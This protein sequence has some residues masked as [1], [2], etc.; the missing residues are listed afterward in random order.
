MNSVFSFRLVILAGLVL[1]GCQSETV[2]KPAGEGV[3][4]TSPQRMS[5]IEPGYRGIAV[6]VSQVAEASIE[7]WKTQDWQQIVLMVD[8]EMESER[9]VQACQLI[10]NAKLP[11]EYFW[12][13]ARCPKLADAHP[14][15]M[16]SLQG[17]DEWRRL[18]PDFPAE[19]SNEVVKT[20]PWVPICYQ[21]S[22]AA[23]LDRITQRLET[24]P[25]PQRVWLHDVQAAPSACGCGHPLCRWTGDYG[26][27]HTAEPLGD[28]A[29]ADFIRK[30]NERFPKIEFVPIWTTEC[31]EEDEH[32]ACGGV[33]CFEGI[34]WNAWTRQL[35]AIEQ[36]SPILGVSS[37][38]K[39]YERDLPRYGQTAA[40]IKSAVSFFE[41][42]PTK[43]NSASVKPDRLVV[44][45]QGWDV[46]DKEI[47]AQVA[48]G[49]TSQ[50][51]GIL[52]VQ[53]Q[54]DQSWEPR[55]FQISN[56]IKH[57]K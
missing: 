19:K 22:F 33:G 25:A 21:E 40:W 54:V 8:D 1:T 52:L 37:F 34:C 47:A 17:H 11:V 39:A 20:Y 6:D 44:V 30:L 42:V 9:I 46:S 51:R 48:H 23:Q 53:P 5:T 18:H 12:E 35:A 13:V 7:Q 3:T 15:W 24:L 29:A 28:S 31:E 43:K 45:L 4:Q 49:L 14:E 36:V 26:P 32:E 50:A 55:I 2:P 27:I 57:D 16:A 10:Q 38:Y 56:D 41:T